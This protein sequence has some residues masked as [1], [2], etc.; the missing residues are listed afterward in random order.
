MNNI[1]HQISAVNLH[2]SRYGEEINDRFICIDENF[3]KIMSSDYLTGASG[4]SVHVMEV[5]V[6][7]DDYK[8]LNLFLKDG[9]PV[10]PNLVYNLIQKSITDI[11]LYGLESVNGVNWY[12]GLNNIIL[13]TIY[14]V[15]DS[16]NILLTTLPFTYI[17]SRF[18]NINTGSY[19][20]IDYTVFN[21][22]LDVSCTFYFQDLN[23][24]PIQ[25][26]PTL[27]YDKTVKGGNFCWKINQNQTGLIAKGPA[28]DNGKPGKCYI[29]ETDD[30]PANSLGM[31]RIDKIMQI[32]PES[33]RYKWTN[34]EDSDSELESGDSVICYL[35]P[36]PDKE[37]ASSHYMFSIVEKNSTSGEYWVYSNPD[38][39]IDSILNEKGLAQILSRIGNGTDLMCLFIPTGSSQTTQYGTYESVRA[40]ALWSDSAERDTLNLGILEDALKRDKSDLVSS[41]T[42]TLNILYDQTN[43]KNASIINETVGSSNIDNASIKTASIASETVENSSVGSASVGQ[44]EIRYTHHSNPGLIA[45]SGTYVK[46][47][48]KVELG[49][50]EK[51]DPSGNIINNEVQILGDTT[52]YKDITISP[53]KQNEGQ[54]HAISLIN[55]SPGGIIQSENLKAH[56][57]HLD[58]EAIDEPILK[59]MKSTL[60]SY[61]AKLEFET[62]SRMVTLHGYRGNSIVHYIVDPYS[63]AK[64]EQATDDDLLSNNSQSIPIIISAITGNL[65]APETAGIILEPDM[66]LRKEYIIGDLIQKEISIRIHPG[67]PQ[68]T[69]IYL[70]RYQIPGASIVEKKLQEFYPNSEVPPGATI[71]INITGSLGEDR[72]FE[73]YKMDPNLIWTGKIRNLSSSN[74]N[75]GM[76]NGDMFEVSER[77]GMGGTITLIYIKSDKSKSSTPVYNV[78][79]VSRWYA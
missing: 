28:G 21:D 35:P 41:N 62:S 48:G 1:L 40:H 13:Y 75:I 23:F 24:V 52:F 16:Q 29:V 10:S 14:E 61:K 72:K 77:G 20:E 4:T 60:E 6:N 45:S 78:R 3:K 49:D 53:A 17:D 68:V 2:E 18:M 9:T 74:G 71:S 58:S 30:T 25:N 37:N 12:D 65:D 26:F 44:L 8:S 39:L 73:L 34:I 57:L 42:G 7:K 69:K 5:P 27:Y 67:A 79:T 47:N 22:L 54:Q 63:I 31:R 66:D 32:D 59:D 56:K 33:N 43:I 64:L 51:S 55:E 70:N 38:C 50:D 76:Q 36:L 11:N 15:R 19:G 46:L